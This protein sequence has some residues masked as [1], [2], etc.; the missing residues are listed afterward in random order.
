MVKYMMMMMIVAISRPPHPVVLRP[1][2]HP[3]KSPE[4]T[5]AMPIPQMPQNP[6][7]RFRLRFSKYPA[8]ACVYVT[9]ETLLESVM[10]I[11]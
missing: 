7:V 3:E 2:F 4:M 1:T 11:Q 5:A 8:L 10:A 9:P 6:A